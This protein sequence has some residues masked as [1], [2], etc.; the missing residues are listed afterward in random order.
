MPQS[1]EG[2]R[3][4]AE[5]DERYWV[6]RQGTVAG[7][8]AVNEQF[9]SQFYAVP[10]EAVEDPEAANEALGGDQVVIDVQTHYVADRDQSTA[11][12]LPVMYRKAM[13]GWWQGLDDLTGYS[14][15]EYLRCVFVETETAVAV[16]S[17]SP[18]VEEHV[19][20]YNS[21]M[22]ATLSSPRRVGRSS[23]APEPRGRRSHPPG[24]ARVDGQMGGGMRR[25]PCPGRCTR[26]ARPTSPP[27]RTC[28]TPAA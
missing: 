4:G 27:T 13:P 9:G 16:L 21:E 3:E 12:H 28:S 14:F 7:L 6:G 18:G 22:A 1:S 10:P 17:S 24:G 2:A 5:S 11:Q 26:S 25:P 20:L 8:L 23:A 19:Q 15:A